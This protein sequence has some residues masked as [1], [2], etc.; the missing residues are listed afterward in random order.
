MSGYPVHP[1]YSFL[2]RDFTQ[3]R[4]K[5]CDW[6]TLDTGFCRVYLIVNCRD[7]LSTIHFILVLELRELWRLHFKVMAIDIIG[8][9]PE[10]L[11]TIN[12]TC[13]PCK[14]PHWCAKI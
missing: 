14:R 9:A 2:Y 4:H 3:K 5:C 11:Q 10:M 13:H 8:I 12:I 7:A 6:Y 1:M